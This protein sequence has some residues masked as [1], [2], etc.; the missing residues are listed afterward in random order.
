[1]SAMNTFTGR[2]FDP[3]KMMKQDVCVEDIAHALSLVCR[4]GGHIR[5][6][7]SVAQHSMNC[8]SEAAARGW[9]G[10]I[11]LACLLHDA[12]EAY[13]A[14]I[15]RPVKPYLTNYLDIEAQIMDVIYDYFE[16]ADLTPEEKKFCKQIDDEMMEHELRIMM[17]GEERRQTPILMSEPDFRE[18]PYRDVE[19]EFK[20]MVE[21][22][23]EN[24]KKPD[25]G[26]KCGVLVNAKA[27]SENNRAKY[28]EA[29]VRKGYRRNF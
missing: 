3:L 14:D 2:I 27:I 11:V 22:Y 8:A 13:I 12:S 6:F 23:T 4:G 17:P 9:S 5:Y 1:M 24:L 21:K 16:L 25:M 10:R 18:R 19:E 28:E 7:F 26:D 29:A 20:G 15:I